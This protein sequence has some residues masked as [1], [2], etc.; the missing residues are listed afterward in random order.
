VGRKAL[1][2]HVIEKKLAL[3]GANPDLCVKSCSLYGMPDPAMLRCP[4]LA[5][6]FLIAGKKFWSTKDPGQNP[7][8]LDFPSEIINHSDDKN[9]LS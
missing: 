6:P 1:H 5:R 3:T 9:H 8:T 2:I 7:F 4:L